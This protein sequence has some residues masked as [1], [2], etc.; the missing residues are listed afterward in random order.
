MR[1]RRP[2]ID[3]LPAST[4]RR[5]LAVGRRARGPPPSSRRGPHWRG[6]RVVAAG[7]RRGRSGNVSL[8]W[9]MGT[10]DVRTPAVGVPPGVFTAGLTCRRL[11]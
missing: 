3:A 11:L 8:G 7:L 5:S 2:R 10:P 6:G 1:R 9:T 4:G